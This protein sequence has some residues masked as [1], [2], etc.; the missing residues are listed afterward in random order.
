MVGVLGVL[1]GVLDVLVGVLLANDVIGAFGIWDGVCDI[2]I[3]KICI[4]VLWI[5]FA[6]K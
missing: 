3:T 6:A 5:N 2:F 1:V 4:Y